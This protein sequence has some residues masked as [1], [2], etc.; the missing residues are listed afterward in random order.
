MNG[1]LQSRWSTLLFKVVIACSVFML[2]ITL[3]RFELEGDTGLIKFLRTFDLASENNTGS[4]WSGMLLLLTSIYM[5]DGYVL[6]R[7]QQPRA[8]QGWIL[9]S[10]ILMVLS[11]DEISSIHERMFNLLD[12]GIWVPP[13]LFTVILFF[14]LVY[15]LICL[16]SVDTQR[17]KAV[18][19]LLGFA[20][21]AIVVIQEIIEGLFVWGPWRA[22]RAVI[23]EGSEL[24]GI[25]ILLRTS[26]SNTGVPIAENSTED[27][28]MLDIICLLRLPILVVGFALAPILAYVTMQL[29][30]PA[31]G[32]P[33]DWFAAVAFFLA[34]FA[35]IRP[36]LKHKGNIGWTGWLLGFFCVL[37]SVMCVAI[38]ITG[39]V[40]LSFGIFN[41]RMFFLFWLSLLILATWIFGSKFRV[42]IYWPVALA[43][44][45]L[46]AISM[47]ANNFLLLYIFQIWIGLLVYYVH[48]R[49]RCP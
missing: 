49:Q 39:S 3:F 45:M 31:R 10:M 19:I 33:A 5:F 18:L 40:D 13:V 12:A 14:M 4:W 25:I 29:S 17:G 41:I 1:T 21:F 43:I 34:G 8:A 44:G 23:E 20:M 36:Y 24:L 9:L 16:W 2:V 47:S 32:H 7:H 48:S 6:N 15:A 46:A 11:A 42:R 35:A 22:L 37:A 27:Y 28:A 38:D 30:D 26:I